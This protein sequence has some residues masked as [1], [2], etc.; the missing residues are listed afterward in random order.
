[1]MD[2]GNLGDVDAQSFDVVPA[3]EYVAVVRDAKETTSSSGTPG[4][5]VDFQIVGG[6]HADRY[7]WDT[8][9]VTQ[10]ALPR[11]RGC[12]EAAGVVIP[13]G[14]F[15]FSPEQL[16]GRVVKL[17]TKVKPEDT[18]NGYAARAEV[19]AWKPADAARAGNAALGTGSVPGA[20]AADDD[21]PF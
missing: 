12:L 10:K 14:R 16:I 13:P 21:I 1:M 20:A 9:W 17:T 8:L 7:L 15:N 11:L 6:P 19:K 18:V 4:I 2:L 3:G 5:A